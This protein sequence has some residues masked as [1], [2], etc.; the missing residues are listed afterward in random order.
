MAV[1]KEVTMMCDECNSV[2][3]ESYGSVALARDWALNYGWVRRNKK[4][5]CPT[6][7]EEQA[8]KS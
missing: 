8:I 2:A 7:Q 1:H 5:I 4:D 3:D 6:C